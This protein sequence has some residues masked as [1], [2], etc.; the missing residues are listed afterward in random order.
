MEYIFECNNLI[1]REHGEVISS[2]MD[3]MYAIDDNRKFL[4]KEFEKQYGGY[5]T[6]DYNQIVYSDRIVCDLSSANDEFYLETS[7]NRINAIYLEVVT[8]EIAELN[9]KDFL[10]DKSVEELKEYKLGEVYSYYTKLA[11]TEY[12]FRFM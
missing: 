6:D 8:K 4:F 2:I 12:Y 7:S 10:S 9:D 11:D 1:C 5:S 3:K